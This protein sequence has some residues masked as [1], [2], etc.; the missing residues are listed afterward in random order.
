MYIKINNILRKNLMI[1][2]FS[3]GIVGERPGIL[4]IVNTILLRT[5][6][7]EQYLNELFIYYT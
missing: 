2:V 1:A 5:Q 7:L 6:K 4:A 3:C